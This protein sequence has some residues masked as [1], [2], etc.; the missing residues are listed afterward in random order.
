MDSGSSWSVTNP[1]AGSSSNERWITTQ[2]VQGLASSAQTISLSYTHQFLITVG[3]NPAGAGSSVP[4]G[5]SWYMASSPISISAQANSPN[6]FTDWSSTPSTSVSFGNNQSSPTT[7]MIS[8]PGT[9]NAN[10]AQILVSLSADSGSATQGASVSLV[11]TIQGESGSQ[12]TLS[13]SGLPG[14][15]NATFSSSNPVTLNSPGITDSLNISVPLSTQPGTYPLTITAA[16]S[17]GDSNSAGYS[18]TVRKAVALTLAFSIS[19]NGTTTSQ[20][21]LNFTYNG[22]SKASP[23]TATPKIFYLDSGSSWH[24]ESILDGST[25]SERWITNK[26]T[27]GTATNPLTMTF[28]YYHQFYVSFEFQIVGGVTPQEFPIVTFSSI[29]STSFVN[30][31][32]S[33]V[34]QWVD[35]QSIYSYS[36]TINSTSVSQRWELGSSNQ[37]GGGKIS[38]AIAMNPSY[39]HQFLVAASFQVV[40][41]ESDFTTPRFS[42]QSLGSSVN[43][44]L[45]SQQQNEVWIDSGSAWSASSMLN[46]SSAAERWIASSNSTTSGTINSQAS[47]LLNYQNQYFVAVNQNVQDG[48]SVQPPNGWFNSSQ[49]ITISAK[50]SNGWQ[51][52][53]WKGGNNGSNN[54]SS[55]LAI[56]VN[57]PVNETAE[58]YAAVIVDASANGQLSYAYGSTTGSSRRF[59]VKDYL[60]AA[61]NKHFT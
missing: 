13:V 37:T 28:G 48:G 18:L 36:R 2:P 11:A 8:G 54:S 55:D 57:S 24:V 39:Y 46:G 14:S 4:S 58:F 60:R 47:I 21:V 5:S 26:T 38:G 42:Y 59:H 7:A 33:G 50:A 29:G 45:V 61:G 53:A 10:F 15:S 51:F 44:S 43:D 22:L 1:L 6:F 56:Q 23:L 32:S 41:G 52:A 35:A 25:S 30:A 27:A 34:K 3:S 40:G 19:D 31:T 12:A 17:G 49:S 16:N 9:I 20:P